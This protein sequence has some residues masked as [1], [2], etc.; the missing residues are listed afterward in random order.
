[1]NMKLNMK[2]VVSLLL[3]CALA[4][5]MLAGCGPTDDPHKSSG[6][7][8]LK[9]GMLTNMNISEQQQAELMKEAG[10]RGSFPVNMVYDIT[11]YD[12][13]NSMQM[14]LESKSIDEMST[15]QCVSDYLLARND[16]FAQTDFK[17]VKLEDGFCCA[18]RE[19]D[20]ELLEEMNKAISAMKDDGT[21]DKLVQEYIK[22]VKA[23]E[24]PHAVELEKAEGRRI[25]KVAVTGD[26]PPIDL[27]LADGKPAG[28]NTAVLSE[29]GK[30]LQRNIEIVQ[31]DSG[32]RAAALSGKTVDVIFWAVIPEDKFNVRPKDFDLPKG[33]ATTVP[34]YK[35]EIVHLAVK[36]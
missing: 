25:L 11:Y 9:L 16:K 30:R 23:G 12:N 7:K 10:P 29:V 27:V 34:Y 33:A 22:D 8:P 24:E 4:G 35:D 28:F 18:V 26:L 5:S 3:G 19:E 17:Q 14:G 1:M 31:V 20:K 15:Y 36:K 21:L 32:A 13:L 2:K 6:G